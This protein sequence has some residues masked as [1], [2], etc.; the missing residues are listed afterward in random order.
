[1]RWKL[2]RLGV[3]SAVA[4]RR[5]VG[6]K[7]AAQR[8][9]RATSPLVSWLWRRR[10]GSTHV[11]IHGPVHPPKV[12]FAIGVL[13]IKYMFKHTWF[14][15]GSVAQLVG[16]L[17][18]TPRGWSGRKLIDVS[19]SLFLS[20]SNKILRWGSKRKKKRA[21]LVCLSGLSASLEVEKLL[22]WFPNKGTCLGFGS[23]KRQPINIS[24]AHRC[25]SLSLSPSIPLS[26]KINKYNLKERKSERKKENWTTDTYTQV[27]EPQKKWCQVNKSGKK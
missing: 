19:V 27:G 21:L 2:S 20:Q 15:P 23:C 17:S 3:G 11:T 14:S 4:S 6:Y 16:V 10:H 8:N 9:F 1:M 25:F 24:L 22:V 5:E 7:G 18:C 26:L 12:H 13:K